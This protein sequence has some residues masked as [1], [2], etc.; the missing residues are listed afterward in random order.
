MTPEREQ[1]LQEAI[2]NAKM[3]ISS[4]SELEQLRHLLQ[5][6]K[7]ARAIYRQHVEVDYLLQNTQKS[8]SAPQGLP[9]KS[10]LL[11]ALIGA[12]IA[13]CMLLAIFYQNQAPH[14][15]PPSLSK[16]TPA[17]SSLASL[18]SSLN[19]NFT[20]LSGNH[21]AFTEG[22][23]GLEQGT[24]QLTFNHGAQVILDGKCD[25]EI[26]GEKHILLKQGKLWALCPPAAYGFTIST[27]DGTHITDLGTAFGVTVSEDHYTEVHVFKGVVEVK[28][29]E[30]PSRTL[31]AGDA[32][33]WASYQPLSSLKKANEDLF[34]TV[35]KLNSQRISNYQNILSQDPTLLTYIDFSKIPHVPNLAINTNTSS[36]KAKASNSVTLLEGRLPQT[37]SALF[38][39]TSSYVSYTLNEPLQSCTINTWVR[40]NQFD[41]AFAAI[42][43]SS[44]WE[45]HGLHLQVTK[46]RA[47]ESSVLGGT[48]LLTPPNTLKPYTWHM[49]TATW[50]I[51]SQTARIYCDGKTI[52]STS[53]YSTPTPPEW[54]AECINIGNAVIGN[55]NP[56]KNTSYR[57][58]SLKG[59]IDELVIFKRVLPPSEILDLYF[60]GKP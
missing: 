8:H 44:G 54:S 25:F 57:D 36:S 3:G 22:E 14:T 32:T 15:A 10:H 19:A 52:Y 48:T 28:P 55:W 38:S 49:I 1:W 59:A 17:S 58:R 34:I 60:E 26:L 20:Q 23:F 39:K 47:I 33:S 50:D 40:V 6:D 2:V 18:H 12:G 51:E 41:K 45:K 56:L 29:P 9:L 16:A 27:P 4:P 21:H 35:D 46:D 24:A 7:Q 11:T 30:H 13:A 5:S 42:I 31:L 37:H 53:K 43:N